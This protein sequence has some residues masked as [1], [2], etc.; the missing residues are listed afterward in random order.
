MRMNKLLMFTHLHYGAPPHSSAFIFPRFL[1][2]HGF[3]RICRLRIY[4]KPVLTCHPPWLFSAFFHQTFSPPHSPPGCKALLLILLRSCPRNLTRDRIVCNCNPIPGKDGCTPPRPPR[5]TRSGCLSIS[6]PP[7]K[8][9]RS[10]KFPIPAHT[11]WPLR[12]GGDI[13][14][15]AV[16][17]SEHTLLFPKSGIQGRGSLGRYPPPFS[18]LNGV[19]ALGMY[20]FFTQLWC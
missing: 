1:G 14:P 19:S 20:F 13:S 2:G 6:H 9:S 10:S 8:G 17:C 3:P 15:F 18:T 4:T 12:W 16:E 7:E 5:K 11:K